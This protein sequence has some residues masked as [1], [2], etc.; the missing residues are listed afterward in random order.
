[1][2]QFCNTI[3]AVAEVFSI[4][5]VFPNLDDPDFPKA[6]ELARQSPDFREIGAGPAARYRASVRPFPEVLLP[7]EY[8]D[9]ETTRKV[10]DRGQVKYQQRKFFLGNAFA[11]LRVALRH[12]STDG[13][14]DVYL[15]HQWVGSIDLKQPPLDH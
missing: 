1:M 2:L 14:L 5:L 4:T 13:L 12:S 9:H 6:L 10:G 8:D 7:I 11:G 15:C 3:G